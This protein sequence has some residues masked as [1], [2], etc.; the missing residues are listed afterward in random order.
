MLWEFSLLYSY[1][2]NLL[3]SRQVKLLSVL[4]KYLLLLTLPYIKHKNV[5]L[6][7][8]KLTN[9]VSSQLL[10]Q[11]CIKSLWWPGLFLTGRGTDGEKHFEFERMTIGVTLAEYKTLCQ[12]SWF[13][14]R[15]R[16]H[17]K[18]IY[19]FPKSNIIRKSNEGRHWR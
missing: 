12:F 7:Y 6:K 4:S 8:D 10:T 14:L 15:W 2:Y 3:H 9:S 1:P 13:K 5:L 18:I 11:V 19:M 17:I 16:V